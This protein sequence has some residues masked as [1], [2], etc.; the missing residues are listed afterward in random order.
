MY[1]TGVYNG[2]S[3]LAMC[4]DMEDERWEEAFM[5][6]LGQPSDQTQVDEEAEDNIQ[7]EFLPVPKISLYKEAIITLED[8]QTFLENCGHLSTSIT[9]GPAVD[10]IT[11][12]KVTSMSQRSIHDYF[13]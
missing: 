12:L 8:V 7:S 2:D 9:C 5:S 11:S 3:E 10:A 6:Q 1:C 4:S 13:S